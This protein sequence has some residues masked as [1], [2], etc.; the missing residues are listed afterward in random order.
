[1]QHNQIGFKKRIWLLVGSGLKD[2][3]ECR[4]NKNKAIFFQ[5]KLRMMV[6]FLCDWMLFVYLECSIRIQWYVSRVVSQC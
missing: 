1:M 3:K 6:W 5:C 4:G 2:V